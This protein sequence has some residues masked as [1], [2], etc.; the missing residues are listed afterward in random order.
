MSRSNQPVRRVDTSDNMMALLILVLVLFFVLGFLAHQ[1]IFLFY[2]FWKLIFTPLIQVI[3]VVANGFVGKL[4]NPMLGFTG[5]QAHALT[6]FISQTPVE[7]WN[8]R[9]FVNM[10]HFIGKYLLVLFFPVGVYMIVSIFKRSQQIGAVFKHFKSSSYLNSYIFSKDFKIESEIKLNNE[11]CESEPEAGG[12]AL[13]CA[14]FCEK[15]NL[16]TINEAEESVSDIDVELAFQVFLNQLGEKITEKSDIFNFKYGWVFNRIIT[17]IPLEHRSEAID[18]ALEGHLYISTALLNLLKTARRFGVVPLQ[19]F[20][21]LKFQNRALWYALTSQGRKVAFVEG[22][23]IVA[24]F[25][26][27]LRFKRERNE[28]PQKKPLPEQ[29]ESAVTG[30][31]QALTE[32]SIELSSRD[33]QS[34]WDHFDSGVI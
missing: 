11:P 12:T 3:D 15:H 21:R 6:Q 7:Q 20:L 17:H 1:Y 5:F 33:N 25:D 26:Y 32:E 14:Q 22:A 31:M 30:L 34:I 27:E 18:Y 9:G 16:I 4:I 29:V 2:K 28:L 10:N 19:P 23:G 8:I 13:S 24:Q